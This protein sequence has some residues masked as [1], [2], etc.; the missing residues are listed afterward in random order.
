MEIGYILLHLVTE[1]DTLVLLCFDLLRLMA[2]VR[3]VLETLKSRLSNGMR[4]LQTPL[5]QLLKV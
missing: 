3:E 2:L 5:H 1:V 4:R